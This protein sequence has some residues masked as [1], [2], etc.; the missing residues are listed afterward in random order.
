MLNGLQI[1]TLLE[2]MNLTKV[3]S[4]TGVSR[5][6]AKKVVEGEINDVPYGVVCKLS[7][8][9]EELTGDKREESSN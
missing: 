4:E 3:C 9:L 2:R 7:D 5:H 8:Y 1:V 6:L